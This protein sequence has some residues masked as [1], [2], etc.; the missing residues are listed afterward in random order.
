MALAEGIRR[1]LSIKGILD[2]KAII[3][4]FFDNDYFQ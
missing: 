2:R 1:H 3:E 4:G